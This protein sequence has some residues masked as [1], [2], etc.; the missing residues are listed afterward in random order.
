MSLFN[1]ESENKLAVVLSSDVTYNESQKLSTIDHF[2]ISDMILNSNA[3]FKHNL[4]FKKTK[5]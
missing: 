2:H 3:Y 1:P 5:E 4:F